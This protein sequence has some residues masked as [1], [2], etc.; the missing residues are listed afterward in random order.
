MGV[1]GSAISPLEEEEE[2][3]VSEA[4]PG[5]TLV[6]IGIFQVNPVTK[7]GKGLLPYFLQFFL[8][9]YYLSYLHPLF[10]PSVISTYQLT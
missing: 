3:R 4:S 6:R 1:G 9:P 2:S 8:P 7:T 5:A 10:G